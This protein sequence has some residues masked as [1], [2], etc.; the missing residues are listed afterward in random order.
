MK[1]LLLLLTVLVLI[2]S[3]TEAARPQ[4]RYV[5]LD[6]LVNCSSVHFQKI[7]DK[8]FY[9]FQTNSDSLFQWVYLNT[10][11]DGSDTDDNG[12]NAVGIRYAGATYD[13]ITRT[14]DQTLDIYVLGSKMFPNRHLV[15]VN[16]G[17]YMVVTYSGSLLNNADIRFRLD[18]ISPQKTLISYEFNLEFGKFFALFVSDKIWNNTIKWRLEQV[19][20]N[21]VEYAETGKVT[22]IE[23]Q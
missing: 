17:P 4:L 20:K 6:S 7:I 14:G 22:K 15:T 10:E 19:F 8:F 12:K 13:P 18:S 9:Q 1:K 23:K 5:Q 3:H 21:M 2:Y 11:G 16:H